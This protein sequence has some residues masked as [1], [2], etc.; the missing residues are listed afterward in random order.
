[1]LRFR[2]F[3]LCEEEVEAARS[4]L[5]VVCSVHGSEHVE[6]ESVSLMVVAYLLEDSRIFPQVPGNQKNQCQRPLLGVNAPKRESA[7]ISDGLKSVPPPPDQSGGDC[8]VWL[9]GF[10]HTTGFAC[11]KVN[12]IQ[13]LLLVSPVTQAGPLDSFCDHICIGFRRGSLSGS[14]LWPG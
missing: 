8:S 5:P 1:M 3:P 4:S 9:C 12:S 10:Y 13:N 2:K 11:G 7:F 6:S 14:L